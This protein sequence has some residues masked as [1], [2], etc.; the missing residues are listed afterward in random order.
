MIMTG[1]P[2]HTVLEGRMVPG[3]LFSS[4]C[5]S[6]LSVTENSSASFSAMFIPLPS[7]TNEEHKK[8]LCNQSSH[9][10]KLGK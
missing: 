4:Q 2:M 3:L 10:G 6:Q 1:K 5:M 9:N 7:V 8:E